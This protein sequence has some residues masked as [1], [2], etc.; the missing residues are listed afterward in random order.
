MPDHSTFSVNRHGR[1]RESDV[2][3]Q[4]FENVVRGCMGAGLVGGEGFAVDAS[5]VEADAGR[6]KRVE[7]SEIDWTDGQRAQRPIREYLAA[8]DGE[9][10]PINPERAPKAL[11]PTDPAAA[12]TT[13]GRYKVMFGYGSNYLIDTKDAVIVDVAPTPTRISKEVDAAELM[14]DRTEERLDLKPDHIAAD[15][16]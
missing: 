16:A 14:L 11:S 4:V 3:R 6:C 8:L 12:G 13:R 2:L 10:A 9:N 15:L 5:V 7:G 1:F